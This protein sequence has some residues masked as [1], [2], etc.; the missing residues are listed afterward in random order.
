MSDV[1]AEGII[2]LLLST[3]ARA[4][5][6][7]IEAFWEQITE[8]QK[9]LAIIAHSDIENG[10]AFDIRNEIPEGIELPDC[11]CDGSFREVNGNPSG[12]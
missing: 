2:P 5:L 10:Q 7:T 12:E 1:N 6:E 4:H 8:C 9:C 3:Q 11:G